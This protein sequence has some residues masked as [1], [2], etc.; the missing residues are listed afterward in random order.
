VLVSG[1][2]GSGK[3]LVSKTLCK[4]LNAKE[5]AIA[6]PMKKWAIEYFDFPIHEC[7]NSRAEAIS[8]GYTDAPGDARYGKTPKS[9]RFLQ[10]LGDLMKD[11]STNLFWTD[12]AVK[13]CSDVRWA[14]SEQREPPIMFVVSDWR[15]PY[16]F[17]QFKMTFMGDVFGIRVVRPDAPPIE[18][19][20]D[21]VSETSLTDDLDELRYNEVIVNDG[22]L[23]DLS[24]KVEKWV[25]RNLTT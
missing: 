18:A 20:A 23:E 16:E 1:R 25:E 2:A 7:Y 22:S 9:R 24:K 12:L 6:G 4:L 15:F 10:R 21:H 5:I 3:G 14:Q 17:D 11:V 13:A 8:A 19:G